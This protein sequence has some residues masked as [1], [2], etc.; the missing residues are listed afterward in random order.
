MKQEL[1]DVVRRLKDWDTKQ[2]EYIKTIP[3]DIGTAFFDNE[4]TNLMS[5]QKD[6]LIRALFGD[7]AED[8]MWFLYEFKAG[9]S[10]GPHCILADG[11]K[12]TY[13]T[14]EDYYAYLE[15]Q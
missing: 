13:N 8:V 12:Y 3:S 7:M 6:M 1:I 9:K 14:N 5:L 15:S 10:A 2:D 4:Y 11:T